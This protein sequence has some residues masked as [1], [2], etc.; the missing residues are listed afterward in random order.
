MKAE[1]SVTGLVHRQHIIMTNE[2]GWSINF[3]GCGKIS[4][5]LR[6][7]SARI[8]EGDL[9]FFPRCPRSNDRQRNQKQER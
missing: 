5:S 3:M 7:I 4:H 8:A 2:N 9:I 1:P 6:S